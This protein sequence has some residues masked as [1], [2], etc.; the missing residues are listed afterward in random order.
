M[1]GAHQ[2]TKKVKGGC[3]TEDTEITEWTNVDFVGTAWHLTRIFHPLAPI[4]LVSWPHKEY[5]LSRP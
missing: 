3:T 1:D 5:F 2:D 4:S